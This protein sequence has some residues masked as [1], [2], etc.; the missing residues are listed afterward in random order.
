LINEI[1]SGPVCVWTF[2]GEASA[3]G[4]LVQSPSSLRIVTDEL[5]IISLFIKSSNDSGKIYKKNYNI[6]EHNIR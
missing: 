1:T 6:A 3:A 5:F 2:K 4:Y